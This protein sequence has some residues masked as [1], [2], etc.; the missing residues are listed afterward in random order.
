MHDQAQVPAVRRL[1]MTA[2]ARVWEAKGERPTLVASMDADSP[3][4]GPVAYKLNRSEAIQLGLVAPYQVLCLDIR[5]PDLY[6]ALTTEATG[7]DAVRGARL[8][9]CHGPVGLEV[10]ALTNTDDVDGLQ[11]HEPMDFQR[12][13][14][15]QRQ[16]A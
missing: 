16:V 4:F 3:V 12:L 2:T 7:S 10:V 9:P 8:A 13:R 1:Y 14:R 5:D 11:R 15:G 6:A